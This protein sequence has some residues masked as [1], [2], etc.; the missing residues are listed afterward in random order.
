ML[1]HRQGSSDSFL[2]RGSNGGALSNN[3]SGS[4]AISGKSLPVSTA[5]SQT[6]C[7]PASPLSPKNWAVSKKVIERGNKAQ[8]GCN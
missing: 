6:T 5:S 8:A 7:A 1:R 4:R 2:N 3:G